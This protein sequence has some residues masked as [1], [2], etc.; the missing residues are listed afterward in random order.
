MNLLIIYF[1][2]HYCIAENLKKCKTNGEDCFFVSFLNLKLF[3]KVS[4]IVQNVA[5]EMYSNILRGLL[6]WIC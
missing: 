6:K 5:V 4:Y 2:L 3:F 1:F